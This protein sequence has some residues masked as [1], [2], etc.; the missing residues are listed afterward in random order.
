MPLLGGY[1]VVLTLAAALTGG[2]FAGMSLGGFAVG[3]AFFFY[4]TREPLQSPIEVSQAAAE[5][6]AYSASPYPSLAA[7]AAYAPAEDYSAAW[8]AEAEYSLDTSYEPS[9]TYGETTGTDVHYAD[10]ADPSAELRSDM[11]SAA[12][13]VARASADGDA[14]ESV[15]DTARIRR[16]SQADRS[17]LTDPPILRAQAPA[18][19][20]QQSLGPPETSGTA[21]RRPDPVPALSPQTQVPA[22]EEPL[23]GTDP[24]ATRSSEG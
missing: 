20:L 11:N 23:Q 17:D 6:P 12:A 15:G 22:P 7:A 9:E 16:A 5:P 24:R 19:P 13:P 21:G 18:S 8:R 4:R 1:K 3:D 2:A 10:I 14:W